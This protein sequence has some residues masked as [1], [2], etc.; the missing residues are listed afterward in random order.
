M[1]QHMSASESLDNENNVTGLRSFI[2]LYKSNAIARLGQR[3][4]EIRGKGKGLELC[5]ALL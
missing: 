4:R 5:V 3:D 2:V 1:V